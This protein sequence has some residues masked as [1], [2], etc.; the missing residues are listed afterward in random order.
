MQSLDL[1]K[2]CGCDGVALKEYINCLPRWS[3]SPCSPDHWKYAD[4]IP[5]FKKGDRQLKVNYHPV[6]LLPNLSKL[7]EKIVFSRI[8]NYLIEIGSLYIYHAGFRPGQSTT[9]Q[10]TFIVHKTY[11][12]LECGKEAWAVFLD[13][14]KA[15]HKVWQHFWA[16]I[17]KLPRP[18]TFPTVQEWC[19]YAKSIQK[20][21]ENILPHAKRLES[22]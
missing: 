14:S 20:G 10:K 16:T 1:S 19:V 13:I 9:S 22:T 21:R 15:F 7:P 17:K 8:Y 11:E 3:T 12:S 4:V 5:L 6:S 2:S 18:F